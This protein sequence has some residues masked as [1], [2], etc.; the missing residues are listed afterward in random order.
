[1]AVYLTELIAAAPLGQYPLGVRDHS[2]RR[3]IRQ[4]IVL[5]CALI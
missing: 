2:S 4:T 5:V 3:Q 1:M